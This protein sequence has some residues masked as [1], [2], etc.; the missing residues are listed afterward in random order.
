MN[1]QDLFKQIKQKKSYLCLGLDPEF[2]K[3]PEVVLSA[4]DPIFEFNKAIIDATHKLIIAIKPNLAFYESL[5]IKGWESLIKTIDYCRTSYPELFLIADAKR[6]DIGNTARH[7]AMAFFREMNF[8]AITLS[9]Y[10][11]K[12]SVSP[13]LDFKDKWAIVLALTSNQ[14]ALDFQLN[15]VNDSNQ[16]LFE[17]VLEK[18]AG[19]GSINQMMFVVGATKSEFIRQVRSIVPHHFLLVPGVGA[20]GGNLEE[21]SRFGLNEIGGLLVNSS[22]GII[23]ASGGSD[24]AEAAAESASILQKE[25]AGYLSNRYS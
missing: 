10:M 11:G 5:G 8:D 13:F 15:R 6:G 24:F 19:Y 18:M 1:A 7:Y 9:P 3:L 14:G 12:D 16:T 2:A 4:Q 23:Y 17:S 22:R 20:Q 25:M 21:I